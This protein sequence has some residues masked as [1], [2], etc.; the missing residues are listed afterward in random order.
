MSFWYSSYTPASSFT[1]A[2]YKLLCAT[3]FLLAPIKT[4]F[5]T[6]FK[7]SILFFHR[8]QMM[9]DCLH[10][11]IDADLD[12]VAFLRFRLDSLVFFLP[13]DLIFGWIRRVEVFA[14]IWNVFLYS[15][16]WKRDWFRSLWK[17]RFW[18]KSYFYLMVGGKFSRNQ[19]LLA[20]IPKTVW[21]IITSSACI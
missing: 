9:D 21:K 20:E 4:T 6:T 1:I 12:M 14:D 19:N 2:W 18:N 10:K 8:N 17:K 13:N 16:C 3:F 5:S 11:P 7:C 15:C